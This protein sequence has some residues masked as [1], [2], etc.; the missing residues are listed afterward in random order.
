MAPR[1]RAGARSP[2]LW[3]REHGAYMQ[4]VFPIV[5]AWILGR[6]S[7]SAVALGLAACVVFVT[8]EPAM[9]LLG[10][11]GPRRRRE[12]GREARGR[13]LLLGVLAAALGAAGL[14]GAEPMV[15]WLTVAPLAVGVPAVLLALT[16]HERSLAGELY[17]GGLF[18]LVAL[19]V[20]VAAGLSP[21]DALWLA[22]AW[23]VGFW[24]G[25]MAA[26]GIL[27]QKRDGGRGLRAAAVVAMT[28]A[29]GGTV[30]AVSGLVPV[31]FAVAPLPFVIVALALTLR[32][33]PPRRMMAI[34]FTLLGACVATMLLLLAA[35]AR[36]DS[37]TP[38][39]GD[40]HEA[41]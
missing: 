8:H 13:L 26:R 29:A 12:Q 6:P 9:V 39:L 24:V 10:R 40:T 7:A 23:T 1:A 41:H 11:R 30:L 35:G 14:W 15:R 37:P 3:P 27:L 22:G 18:A 32:P 33:P 38:T 16:G 21:V 25:T 31:A 20:A 28:V 2:S 17:L 5:S 36:A 19:P 34:G 4:L